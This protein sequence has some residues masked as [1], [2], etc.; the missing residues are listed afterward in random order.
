MP[1]WGVP[2]LALLSG[3]AIDPPATTRAGVDASLWL[4]RELLV[5]RR[6]EQTVTQASRSATAGGLVVGRLENSLER[7]DDEGFQRRAPRRG[8]DLE[9]S[10]EVFWDVVVERDD[11]HHIRRTR[12]RG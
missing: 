7:L 5:N 3:I 9:A 10:V 4:L 6:E 1:D 11:T 2:G 12:G 8:L